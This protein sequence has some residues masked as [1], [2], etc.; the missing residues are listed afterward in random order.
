[1][2]TLASQYEVKLPMINLLYSYELLLFYDRRFSWERPHR[3]IEAQGSA[4]IS[5]FTSLIAVEEV[6]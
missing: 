3:I 5:H 6:Q 2:L 4:N 1:M